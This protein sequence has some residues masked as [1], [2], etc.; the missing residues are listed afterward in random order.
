[1]RSLLALLALMAP[2]APAYATY[3]EAPW[4][5]TLIKS[6]SVDGVSYTDTLRIWMDRGFRDR[7]DGPIHSWSE[8]QQ[9]ARA[10]CAICTPRRIWPGE[11]DRFQQAKLEQEKPSN[12]EPSYD[13][14]NQ[15]AFLPISI[16]V[17]GPLPVAGI[18]MWRNDTTDVVVVTFKNGRRYTSMPGIE[19][20]TDPNASMRVPS[21]MLPTCWQF[22]ALLGWRYLLTLDRLKM[23]WDRNSLY[24]D[25]PTENTFLVPVVRGTDSFE[26]K[27]IMR[28]KLLIMGEWVDLQPQS[29][30]GALVQ[31]AGR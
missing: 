21:T 25:H 31:Q 20:G 23:L 4:R 29:A 18:P 10:I 6:Y 1:M 2:A 13:R 7:V 8:T 26:L 3:D 16:S 17:T 28:I 9:T 30:T 5:A 12:K 22:K 19:T 11:E 14:L 27:Q 24:A 15:I